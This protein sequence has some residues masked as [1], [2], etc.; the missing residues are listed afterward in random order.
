[1]KLT[2][3]RNKTNSGILVL[4]H[5]NRKH[6]KLNTRSAKVVDLWFLKFCMKQTHSTVHVENKEI[7]VVCGLYARISLGVY[8][9]L[10]DNGK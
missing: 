1:M 6:G 10:T 5:K 3:I 2:L 9:I 8:T 4:R 7:M